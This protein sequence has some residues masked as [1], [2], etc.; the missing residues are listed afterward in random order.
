MVGDRPTDSEQHEGA[1]DTEMS[2]SFLSSLPSSPHLGPPTA[3]PKDQD[4]E[5]DEFSS[6]F[7]STSPS[8]G[9]RDRGLEEG[10]TPSEG[11]SSSPMS[12][13]DE[14]ESSFKYTIGKTWASTV[15]NGKRDQEPQRTLKHRECNV[16]LEN[17]VKLQNNKMRRA[18]KKL[19][20]DIEG[21][22]QRSSEMLRSI[23]SNQ[24]DEEESEDA[25]F[26]SKVLDMQLQQVQDR[27]D[28]FEEK[29]NSEEA[30][31]RTLL[32]RGFQ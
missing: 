9:L 6:L 12:T 2:T 13:L 5:E 17:M 10:E 22:I 15:V 29:Q 19:R 14:D 24:P 11:S 18:V 26:V 31:N 8:T 28:Q 21:E 23:S 27:F 7:E 16:L 25:P 20:A 4:A 32:S 1:Q 30:A 3:T